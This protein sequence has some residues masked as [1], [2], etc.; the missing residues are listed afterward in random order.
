MA[1]SLP[2]PYPQL[3]IPG[4]PWDSF[5]LLRNLQ[6]L[7]ARID[8][9]SATNQTTVLARLSGNPVAQIETGA[10]TSVFAVSVPG[11]T[12]GTE[13]G[14][15][16]EVVGD[17]LSAG[18]TFDLRFYYGGTVYGFLSP[19]AFAANATRYG[20]FCRSL[21]IARGATN[22]QVGSTHLWGS[23]AVGVTGESLTVGLGRFSCHHSLA[24]NSATAQTLAV[25]VDNSS[26]AQSTRIF[27]V[28][29]EGI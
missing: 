23:T 15:R 19:A 24:I 14:L 13:R 25:T 9:V 21:L 4:N 17:F 26:A 16:I 28:L 6:F 27:S 2:Y 12:L 8:D 3:D 22:A 29:V 10:E 1:I 11:D 5:A 20:W 18:G 7:A